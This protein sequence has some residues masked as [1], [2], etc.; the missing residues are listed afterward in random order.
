MMKK[1]L[2]ILLAVILL[3]AIVIPAAA[4][5]D[6]E[7]LL[8]VGKV[9]GTNLGSKINGTFKLSIN[10]AMDVVQSVEYRIDGQ[11]IGTASASPFTLVFKTTEYPGGEHQ[12]TAVVNL[13][14]GRSFETP[15]RRFHFISSEESGEVLN[16]VLLPILGVTFGV[17]AL[18][19]LMQF[20]VMRNRPLAHLEPGTPRNYGLKGGTIC[21]HCNRPF[22]FH[23]WAFNLMPTVRY[24]RC[25]YCGKWGV[26]R[27]Y[28]MDVLCK[29]EELEIELARPET[30]I[31]EKSEEEKLKEMMDKTKYTK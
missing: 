13:S 2:S 14:D 11:A 12:L 19:M 21:K 30:P 20:V 10:G 26:Q 15:A 22:A 1:R 9:F 7:Y 17:V 31:P 3:L 23:W 4:Q 6:A 8:Q 28:P 18:M 5:S 25:D 16:Q 27:S 29:A 24:D